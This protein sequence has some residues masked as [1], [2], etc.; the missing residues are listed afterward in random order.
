MEVFDAV[1]DCCIT[2]TTTT[3]TLGQC[4]SMTWQNDEEPPSTLYAQYT[5]SSG[6]ELTER[7]TDLPAIVGAFTTT[8]FVCSYYPVA[9]R[10]ILNN[11]IDPP[12]VIACDPYSWQTQFDSCTSNFDCSS[13]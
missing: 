6:V 10:C 13:I 3:T 5:N 1:T 12:L 9:P 2:T 8:V 11:G 7:V 4:W